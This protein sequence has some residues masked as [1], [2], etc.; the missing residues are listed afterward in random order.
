MA[1][2]RVE[3]AHIEERAQFVEFVGVV[4]FELC[5]FCRNEEEEGIFE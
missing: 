1:V 4:G 3:P 2:D 5:F